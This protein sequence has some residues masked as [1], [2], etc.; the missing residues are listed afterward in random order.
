MISVKLTRCTALSAAITFVDP[1]NVAAIHE[2]SSDSANPTRLDPLYGSVHLGC[3]LRWLESTHQICHL[4]L[5]DCIP[6]AIAPPRE[7]GQPR[8]ADNCPYPQRGDRRRSAG[9]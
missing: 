1:P 8:R 7:R 6:M 3:G 9:G 2:A 5:C 4:P